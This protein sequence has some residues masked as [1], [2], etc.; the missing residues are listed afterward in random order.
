MTVFAVTYAFAP[1]SAELRD[2]VRP[3]H[4]AFLDR[5]L[6]DGTLLM[7]GPLGQPS[8]SGALLLVEAESEQHALRILEADPYC[9]EGAVRA[10]HAQQLRVT[11]L[12]AERLAAHLP[13]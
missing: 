7:A 3:Q 9:A 13:V 5:A 2:R 1:D 4:R 10:M 8:P 6:A 12:A 11:R